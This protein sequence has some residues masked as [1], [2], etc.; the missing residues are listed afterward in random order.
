MDY[1]YI[2]AI[3]SEFYEFPHKYFAM[4]SFGKFSEMNSQRVSFGRN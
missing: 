1:I 2:D 3:Y 4:H